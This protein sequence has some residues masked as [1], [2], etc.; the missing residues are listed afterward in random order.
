MGFKPTGRL[1]VNPACNQHVEGGLGQQAGPAGDGNGSTPTATPLLDNVLDWCGSSQCVR[2][3]F[4]SAVG[5]SNVSSLVADV[6]D[7]VV[8]SAPAVFHV[9]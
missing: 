7:V 9:R 5:S 8:Q 2:H 4:I 6:P 1:C 3:R